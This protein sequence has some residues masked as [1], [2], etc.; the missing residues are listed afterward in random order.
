MNENSSSLNELY[1]K[2]IDIYTRVSTQEQAEEGYSLAE[3]ERK[4]RAYADAMGYKINAIRSDP[5]ISGSTL[6]RPGIQAVIDDVKAHKCGKVIV[7]KLD[8]LSRSQKDMMILLEDVFAANDCGFISLSEN[9]DTSTPIGKCIV[10][11]LA[12]FAQMERENIRMRTMMGQRAA[13]GQGK[14]HGG[15]LPLGYMVGPDR[16][17]TP[18]P[19]TSPAV[20]EMFDLYT[21]GMTAKKI[22]R[23]IRAKYGIFTAPRDE[24]TSLMV[25]LRNPI[26]CGRGVYNGIPQ[27]LVSEDVWDQAQ[28]RMKQ[29]KAVFDRRVKRAGLLVGLVWCGRC[30]ARLSIHK[31]GKAHPKVYMRNSRIQKSVKM[32]K[33]RNCKNPVIYQD[34]LE[35]TV[36][37]QIR[38][39][40]LA[41]EEAEESQPD[42]APYENRLNELERQRER[43]LTL[44]QTGTVELEDIKDRLNM[45]KTQKED[46][47]QGLA[48]LER[49]VKPMERKEAIELSDMIDRVDDEKKRDIILALIQKIVVDGDDVQIYWNF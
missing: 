39:F 5:G 31:W 36:L 8:R 21:S 27:T 29:N 11:V 43:L 1:H 23:Q 42:R 33:D 45:L 34:T 4:L 48:A 13:V 22:V 32:V 3:Q 14:W 9:F 18:D 15:R 46:V 24:A 17:L 20:K 47:E 40:R 28:E 6:D 7:W 10:G 44:Y 12:A 41:P 30:G 38:E 25:I 19:E 16:I 37:N 35:G 2:T 49:P 26:Y